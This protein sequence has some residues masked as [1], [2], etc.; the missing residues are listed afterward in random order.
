MK[1]GLAFQDEDHEEAVALVNA[2]QTC[3]DEEFPAAYR[4]LL[5]HTVDHLK[6][7]DDLMARIGFFAMEVHTSEHRR[8]IDEMH[9]YLDKLKAGD[10][11]A[12]RA[13]VTDAV[14]NWFINHLDTMDTATAM[15]AR[16]MGEH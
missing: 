9:H 4:R 14:P 7:E 1:R 16:Q 3:T 8:V 2:A 13:Y 11:A 5:D 15:F 6:R 12:V 10:I